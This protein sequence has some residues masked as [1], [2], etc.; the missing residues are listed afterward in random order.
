MQMITV[1]WSALAIFLC[2]SYKPSM[3][4]RSRKFVVKMVLLLLR[5]SMSKFLHIQKGPGH[6]IVL[7][8]MTQTFSSTGQTFWITTM[9]ISLQYVNI[10]LRSLT[11]VITYFM[12]FF[13]VKIFSI[14][15]NSMADERTASTITW[16]NS[17]LRNRQKSVTL[18]NQV[19]IRQWYTMSPE[20]VRRKFPLC[21]V[22]SYC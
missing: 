2:R 13:A 11:I 9:L 6:S 14:T 1:S 19:Q 22:Y 12:K 17:A 8:V 21:S 7:S 10:W 4:R 3:N 16:L 15:V 18:I 5:S 20:N